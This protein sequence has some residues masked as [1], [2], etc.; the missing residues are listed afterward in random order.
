M[1]NLFNLA[2]KPT[3]M[4][5]EYPPTSRNRTE[6][7]W[8]PLRA[9]GK[10]TIIKVVSMTPVTGGAVKAVVNCRRRGGK[11][12]NGGGGWKRDVAHLN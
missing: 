3:E 1:K 8:S 12:S 4:Q 7:T 9:G 5:S 10:T 2:C 6:S 11:G